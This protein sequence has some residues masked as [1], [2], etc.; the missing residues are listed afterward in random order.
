VR[1]ANGHRARAARSLGISVRTL[2]RRWPR[3][4]GT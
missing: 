3:R 2:A 4:S 1:K